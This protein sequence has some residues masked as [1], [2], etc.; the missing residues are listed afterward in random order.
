[1]ENKKALIVQKV[2]IP[3][4]L[5]LVAGTSLTG[6]YWVAMPDAVKGGLMGF[7]IGLELMGVIVFFKKRNKGPAI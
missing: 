5:L 3:L 2:L 1:M 4:G 7:G 6:H